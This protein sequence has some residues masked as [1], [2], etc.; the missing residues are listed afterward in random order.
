M[1]TIDAG[2]VL[3][4]IAGVTW[5]GCET[6]AVDLPTIDRDAGRSA[7]G[8]FFSD[9]ALG[10]RDA[11]GLDAGGEDLSV[12]PPVPAV[13]HAECWDAPTRPPREGVLLGDGDRV[14]QYEV[15]VKPEEGCFTYRALVI[16][17]LRPEPDS[18]SQLA[19]RH[20]Y[21][22]GRSC[23]RCMEPQSVSVPDDGRIGVS[24]S[25]YFEPHVQ[26]AGL[27]FGVVSSSSVTIPLL[28]KAR[29][30]SPG[31]A[32]PGYFR[33][34]GYGSPE[35]ERG[36][37][38]IFQWGATGVLYSQS[39]ED[40]DP[41]Y[42]QHLRALTDAPRFDGLVMWADVPNG[43]AGIDAS[44]FVAGCEELG[45]G[46]EGDC[47]QSENA[48]AGVDRMVFEVPDAPELLLRTLEWSWR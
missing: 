11:G 39:E 36:F 16:F 8:G 13:S 17:R 47:V 3:L 15:P 19:L 31:Y 24:A 40:V 25:P 30:E 4:L 38:E 46:M 42:V 27:N 44:A 1:P 28:C 14:F 7:D 21:V 32:V 37:R 12:R 20:A 18:P 2:R 48:R 10:V 5:L 22:N 34:E 29:C 41:P 9:A 35:L 6:V 43:K 33:G 26:S 45:F 23:N